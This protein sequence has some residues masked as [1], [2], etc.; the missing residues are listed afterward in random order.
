MTVAD[1]IN[2]SLGRI[3]YLAQGETPNA[4]DLQDAFA[5]F[6]SM[7][8]Q[9]RLERLTVPYVKRTV[10]NLTSGKGGPL[11]P[12]TVGT[13]GDVSV[14]RPPQPNEI[15]VRYQDTSA[16][17]TLER[18]LISLTDEA[19]ALIPQKDLTSPLPGHYYYNPTYASGLG[20][21]HF[22]LVP[23]SSTLQG[24]LYAPASIEDFTATSDTIVLPDGYD[25]ALIDNLAVYL[26]P[27]FRENIPPNPALVQSAIEAKQNLKRANFRMSDLHVDGALTVRH[28]MRYNIFSDGN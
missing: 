21:L 14:Y 5:A 28:G 17:P 22:W 16:S 26:A 9:W 24:V 6:K 4:N 25:Y 19:W 8:G 27:Q 20:S 15:T 3:N 18:P 13:G 11:T 23:T 12:Y 7:L 2:R 1:L 10:W